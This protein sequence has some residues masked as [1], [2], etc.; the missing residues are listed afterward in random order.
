MIRTGHCHAVCG[1][2]HMRGSEAH[3]LDA[4]WHE[5]VRMSLRASMVLR[6]LVLWGV[7]SKK[8][9]WKSMTGSD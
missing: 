9:V 5:P 7:G 8:F 6:V 4:I 2:D 3:F 1:Y